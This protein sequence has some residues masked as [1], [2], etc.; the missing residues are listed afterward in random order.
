MLK[1]IIVGTEYHPVKFH[2]KVKHLVFECNTC[3]KRF[4][5]LESYVKKQMKKR[6]NV[7]CFCSADC[8]VKYADVSES[9]EK[10]AQKKTSGPFGFL[11][12]KVFSD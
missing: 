8:R 3:G 1:Q 12:K 10:D 7:C 2:G 6:T 5:K 11:F 4:L 9:R